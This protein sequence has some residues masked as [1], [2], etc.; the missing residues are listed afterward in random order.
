[1]LAIGMERAAHDRIM[2]S[3]ALM[4]AERQ[5]YDDNTF[6]IV[7]ARDILHHVE[8][9]ATMSEIVRVSKPNALLIV[10]EIYS[11]SMTELVSMSQ[12]NAILS[13]IS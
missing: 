12:N 5:N 6:D 9:P 3:F 4:A 2:V 8:I 10:N 13:F 7:Y 11:H 1:M